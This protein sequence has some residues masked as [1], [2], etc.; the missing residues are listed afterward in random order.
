MKASETIALP[1]EE[2]HAPAPAEVA[3]CFRIPGALTSV[4]E[5]K[6]GHIN[7]TYILTATGGDGPQRFILQRINHHVFSNVPEV[8]EN[9]RRVTIHI[10]R[11]LEQTPGGEPERGT[12]TLIPTREG[13]SLLKTAD[14]HYWRMY[15]FIGHARTYDVV[16]TRQQAFEAARAYGRFQRLLADLPDPPLHE[17]I[18]YFHDTPR[19]FAALEAAVHED[20]CGRA[21]SCREEI[22]FAQTLKPIGGAVVEALARGDVPR[23][24]THNDTKINN[25]LMDE[26]TGLG[27]CVI[28]LDTVM[29]GSV[30][31]D[32]GDLMRS[33]VGHFREDEPDLRRVAVVLDLFE[34]L[35]EGYL[36]E[37]RGFLN[38]VEV[39]LLPLSGLL[40]T[41]MIGIRFLT[42]YL[43]GDTYFK[44]ARPGHNL[45]RC[46]TQFALVRGI[47]ANEA[48][49]DAIVAQHAAG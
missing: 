17:T 48:A 30:L 6:K 5:W 46:R 26:R 9:I 16:A 38:E 10:R 45:D 34:A 25:V 24:V 37:A 43:R 2:A 40:I 29:P 15:R 35:V 49:L 31:Y 33:S 42:D 47:R 21:A 12:L 36:A 13:H 22:A 20:V 23:R 27:I 8:M 44:T 1:A 28:D 3:A 19:R 41:F 14:A 32:F 18:P 39:E 11:K 4:V 7:D